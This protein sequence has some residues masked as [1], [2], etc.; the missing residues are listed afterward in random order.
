MGRYPGGAVQVMF[1]MK[2]KHSFTMTGCQLDG[3][4]CLKLN[5]DDLRWQP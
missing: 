4:V 3:A 2:S 5:R 1:A